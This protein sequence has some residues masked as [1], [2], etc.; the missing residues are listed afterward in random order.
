MNLT[1]QLLGD[2]MQCSASRAAPFLTSC[3]FA[4]QQYDIST[5]LRLAHFASQVGHETGSLLYMTELWGP[6]DQQKKYDPPSSVATDLGNTQKGDGFAF[7]GRGWI[8]LTGRA[9]YQRASRELCVDFITKPDELATPDFAPVIGGLFW[10]WRSLNS[11]ADRDDVEAVTRRVNGGY[12]GID[13]R[14]ARLAKAK[15]ILGIA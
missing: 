8:Q 15:T 5:T 1:S 12:T 7:R 14:K 10:E 13:D 11:Y 4:L 3:N 2:L 6:T 9:N